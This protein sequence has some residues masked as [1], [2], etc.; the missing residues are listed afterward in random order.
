MKPNRTAISIFGGL[1][2][3][4]GMILFVTPDWGFGQHLQRGVAFAA[5]G[6]AVMILVTQWCDAKEQKRNPPA[7][8]NTISPLPQTDPKKYSGPPLAIPS[9]S[10]GPCW[11]FNEYL[12]SQMCPDREAR[13]GQASRATFNLFIDGPDGGTWSL[14]I[15]RDVLLAVEQSP[16]PS[17]AFTVTLSTTTFNDLVQGVLTPQQAFYGRKLRVTGNLLEAAKV[18]FLAVGFWKEQHGA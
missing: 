5:I 15:A 3:V 13:V 2:L 18:A 8:T 10:L 11:Y 17:P 1:L 4:L 9:L 16:C 7:P 6:L 14:S 12:P